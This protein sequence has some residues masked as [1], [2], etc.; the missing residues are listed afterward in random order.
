MRAGAPVIY[1]GHLAAGAWHGYPDFLF[2]VPGRLRARRLPLQ[3]LGHQARPLGQALLP[4]PALRL[5]R[6]A[7]DD[8]GRAP[9]GAGVRA[10]QR[11]T[12]CAS[13]PGTSSTTTASSSNPSSASRPAW[14]PDCGCPIPALDR[15]WG[16]WSRG[17]RAAARRVRPP[18]PRR[19]HHPRPGPPAGGRRHR[20]PPRPG[21]DRASRAAPGVST[22]VFERLRAPGPAPARVARQRRPRLAAP[23]ADPEEPRR[24]LALLPPPSPPG[25]VLRHGGLPLRR[26]RQLEYLFGARDPER[27]DARR[28]TTGGPTT[29]P[30]SS[31]A[32]EGF[33]DWVVERLEAGPRRSTST[34]TPPTRSPRSSGSTGKYATREEEVDDLLRGDVFVDLYTVVRQGLV[35]RDAELLA[36]G[37]RAPLPAPA[38][39]RRGVGHRLGDRVPALARPRA[40]RGVGGL[41]DPAGDPRLQRGGLRVHLG[42]A[43]WLLERQRESGI[44]YLPDPNGRPE[45]SGG[46]EPDAEDEVAEQLAD[47]HGGRASRSQRRA[48]A[49]RHADRMAGRVPPAGREADVVADVRTSRKAPWED[50]RRRCRLSR[51]PRRAPTTPPR[52]IKRSSGLR[53]PLRSRSGHQAARGIEVLRR[54]TTT[55]P[56]A[57]SL[58]MDEDA[59]LVELKVGPE[60]S[61]RPTLPHSRRVHLR[62][63]RSSRPSAATPPAW[64]QRQGRSPRRW[65]TCCAGGR[66][67]SRATPADRFC[68]E[69]A[70]SS[71]MCAIWRLGWTAPPSAS[72][73]RPAPA[74]PSPR[75]R[76]SPS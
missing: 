1:Q 40:S 50:L 25:R 17:R 2:R 68:P 75:P 57:R 41:A 62:G 72:R 65:T 31:A 69:Q 30:R 4:G 71:P 39:G 37:D 60:V 7:G 64:E 26:G 24:G 36:E 3:R 63:G 22:P 76:S 67:E 53:V 42:A 54:R 29:T 55:T 8:S 9:G 5:R 18:E 19:Q 28:S 33:I 74:R 56:D 20:D 34:T 21:R 10:R 70:S 12:S 13:R 6:D 46:A 45:R 23:P 15:S 27:R 14:S 32:F 44:A 73:D 16:R 38:H 51:R 43:D 61:P 49:A 48:Q 35:D 59:G 47:R 11:A 66:L 58:A 52:K